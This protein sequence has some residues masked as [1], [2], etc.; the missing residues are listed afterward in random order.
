MLATALYR[1]GRQADA[2]AA[3]REARHR[4]LDEFGLE[5]G[6][7]LADLEAAILRQDPALEAAAEPEPARAD[8]PYHGLGAFDVTD[9]DD[10]FGREDRGRPSA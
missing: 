10:F 6:R 3:L 1:C 8:C 2:L 5:P 7:E 9:A 4:L